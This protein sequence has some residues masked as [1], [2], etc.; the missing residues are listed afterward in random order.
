MNSVAVRRQE[1]RT[2]HTPAEVSGGP[3]PLPKTSSRQCVGASEASY[4][5]RIAANAFTDLEPAP[6]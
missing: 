6:S 5:A 4:G 3:H 2:W 1:R